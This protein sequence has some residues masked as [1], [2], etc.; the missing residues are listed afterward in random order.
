[1]N[2]N[3]ADYVIL[4]NIYH[5]L[6]VIISCDSGLNSCERDNIIIKWHDANKLMSKNNTDLSFNLY[7]I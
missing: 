3:T 4:H 2:K 5:T 7:N 6:K 1:M